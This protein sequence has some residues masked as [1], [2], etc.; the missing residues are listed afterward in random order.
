MSLYYGVTVFRFITTYFNCHQNKWPK[1]T[2]LQ[3]THCRTTEN[4][5][6]EINR[7]IEISSLKRK[8]IQTCGSRRKRSS[9]FLDLSGKQDCQ[10]LL[11]VVIP[12][13]S[14]FITWQNKKMNLYLALKLADDLS[15]LKKSFTPQEHIFQISISPFVGVCLKVCI[16]SVQVKKYFTDSSPTTT[17]ILMGYP[18]QT[19]SSV[20]AGF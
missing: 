13:V 8:E 6:H 7:F 2:L 15:L 4:H 3:Y 18:Y 10:R 20:I 9:T 11:D 14:K 5:K 12:G 1:N 17:C 19:L 16:L